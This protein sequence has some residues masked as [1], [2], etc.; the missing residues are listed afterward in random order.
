MKYIYQNANWPSFEWN[1]EKLMQLL[2]DVTHRQGRLLGRMEGLGFQLQTEATLQAIT[3]E[4]IKSNEIEGQ[5]LDVDQVRS[6]IARKLGLDVAGLVPSDR[7]VDGIVEVILDATRNYQQELTTDRLFGWQ[8]ALFPNGRSAMRKI[9]IGAWRDN[10]PDHP[11][12]VVS[13]AMG[14]ER[15]HFQAPPSET[16]D[17]EMRQ[18]LRWFNSTMDLHPIIKSAIAHLWFVT[19]HPFDDGNGR[20]ARTIA[21]MQL[22]R[23]DQTSQRF[24]SMSAQIRM[25]RSDYYD[26]LERTQRGSLDITLWLEWFLGC[27]DRAL[28]AADSI[29][30]NVIQKARFWEYLSTKN[31]NDRQRLMLNKLLDGFIGKLNSSKWAKLTKCSQDT[32]LRDI[33]DLIQQNVLVQAEEGGRSTSYRLFTL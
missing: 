31:L 15:V 30:G 29:T 24:Y 17:S 20:V 5:T 28:T 27:L 12:Q 7:F 26:V 2:A 19:L 11:M 33:Q 4:V 1:H 10:T 3:I 6:S 18:F 22:A 16:L 21:D 32:A 9:I 8:S 23:A 13:G 25:D 14:K